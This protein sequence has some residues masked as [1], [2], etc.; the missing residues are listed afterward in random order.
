M[1]E[2]DVEIPDR[3]RVVVADDGTDV[4]TGVAERVDEVADDMAGGS[5][6]HDH[7]TRVPTGPPPTSI[8]FARRDQDH[9]MSEA[10]RPAMLPLLAE[11]KSSSGAPPA[12]WQPTAAPIVFRNF[13]TL[14]SGSWT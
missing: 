10:I 9:A 14:A 6:D 2:L 12:V 7:R 11:L 4:A 1:R 3:S 13:G 5:S 8:T